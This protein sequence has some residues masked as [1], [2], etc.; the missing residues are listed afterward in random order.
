MLI[1]V[2]T[3]VQTLGAIVYQS[4]GVL[5]PFLV[6]QLKLSNVALGLLS[7]AMHVGSLA[8]LVVSAALLDRNGPTRLLGFGSLLCGA[9]LVTGALGGSYLVLAACLSVVG[10]VWGLS[11][12]AGGE[13]IVL[14]APPRHRATITSVRQLALPVGGLIAALLG[15]VAVL[16]GWQG[17]MIGQAVAF[18][19][20]AAFILRTRLLPVHRRRQSPWLQVP[21]RRGATLGALAIGLTAAQAAFL[22]YAVLELTGRVGLGFS[23]AALLLV[24]AQGTG[25]IWR[26]LLGAISDAIPLS[27]TSLLALNALAAAAATVVFGL[28]QPDWPAW[29]IVSSVLAAA[30]LIIGWNGLLVVAILEAD[31]AD[32]VNRNLGGGMMLMRIGIIVG[33][34]VFGMMLTW[35][36][37]AVAWTAVATVFLMVAAV[38]AVMG[39]GLMERRALA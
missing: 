30:G 12:I 22:V 26:V 23:Q 2:A 16:V 13:T 19:V 33:P 18:A 38:L 14:S 31:G 1:L 21:T 24:A 39:P 29:I 20:V 37:A 8:A 35:L 15:P 3:A 36:G 6:D 5:A 10:A 25:A 9:M 34:P 4:L 7:S 17:L 11:A 32:E 28:L 27:R